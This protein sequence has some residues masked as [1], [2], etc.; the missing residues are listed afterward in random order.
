MSNWLYD[1]RKDIDDIDFQILELIAKRFE[2]IRKVAD[3]KKENNI[4][5]MQNKRVEQVI[6]RCIELGAKMNLDTRFINKIYIDIIDEACRVESEI[7]DS[8]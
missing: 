5:M 1:I 4:P 8:R 2:I 7:I 3:Y 6:E